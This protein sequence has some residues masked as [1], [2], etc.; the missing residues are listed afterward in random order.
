LNRLPVVDIADVDA[1]TAMLCA[2]Y[3]R[4]GR[5]QNKRIAQMW[6]LRSGMTR[7][8]PM[9][10]R[11]PAGRAHSRRPRRSAIGRK[12]AARAPGESDPHHPH[13]PV[14]GAAMSGGAA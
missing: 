4:R 12:A 6:A 1:Y 9:S 3:E 2:E 5:I 13:A 7:H 8:R 11:N 10:H 14:C